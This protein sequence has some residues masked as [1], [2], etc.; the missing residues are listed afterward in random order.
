MH[1]V[2]LVLK[3]LPSVD[4]DEKNSIAKI[5]HFFILKL[6]VLIYIYCIYVS[7]NV[8]SLIA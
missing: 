7:T 1:R 2:K 4:I 8:V 5:L 6:T 3:N